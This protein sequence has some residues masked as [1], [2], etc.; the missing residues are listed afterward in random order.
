MT[1][2]WVTLCTNDTY[3]LGALVLARSLRR[4]ATSKKLHIIVT[5]GV[6]ERMREQ[7]KSAFD[8]LTLVNVLDSKDE[9]N[10]AL[11][12]RP[13]LG[14]TFTKIHCWLLTQ[15]QKCVFLDADCV[16]LQNCDDLF[17]YPELSAA[18]DIGWPDIFNSGVFVFVPSKQTFDNLLECALTQGSFDGGDQ[19]LLNAYFNT[20]NKKS[21]TRLPFTYNMSSNIVYTYAAAWK[22][23]AKDVKIVHFLGAVKPWHHN[24]DVNRRTLHFRSDSLTN[25]DYVLLWWN[26]FTD[27]VLQNL[28][29]EYADLI[30]ARSSAAAA[31]ETSSGLVA[32][33]AYPAT[34]SEN[35]RQAAWE[36][37]QIDY[38]GQDSWANIEKHLQQ[39]L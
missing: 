34:V 30:V 19:G 1:E 16:L 29:K 5:P 17:Q 14:V 20:W 2:A 37:G 31:A 9:A 27:E 33:V 36:R 13:E 25:Y 32:G 28:P 23:F 24:F 11:I 21:D 8:F 26:I 6:S 4:S 39:Q 3:S 12:K 35:E 10:L 7:L 15:Y 22:R 38:H 18:P